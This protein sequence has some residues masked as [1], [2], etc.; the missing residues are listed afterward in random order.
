[1]LEL[2]GEYIALEESGRAQSGPEALPNAV[3]VT[4]VGAIAPATLVLDNIITIG[5]CIVLA[6]KLRSTED[7]FGVSQEIQRVGCFTLAALGEK[8]PVHCSL[9]SIRLNSEP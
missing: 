8:F 2:I 6:G 3:R 4:S 7:L 9:H 5:T 1:M